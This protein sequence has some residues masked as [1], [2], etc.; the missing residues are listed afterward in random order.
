M[1]RYEQFL[2]YNI[3]N[4]EQRQR[5]R[6]IAIPTRSFI[7]DS[8]TLFNTY[9]LYQEVNQRNRTRW[10]HTTNGQA[11]GNHQPEIESTGYRR[12]NRQS[13]IDES[14]PSRRRRIEE[15]PV[16]K[17]PKFIR[18]S[19]TFKDRWNKEFPDKPCV[20]C[21]TLLLPRHRKFRDFDEDH[22]YG[23]TKV[24][25]MPVQVYES[26]V[27]VCESC[28][29]H[30]KHPIDCGTPPL[31]IQRLPHRSRKFISPFQLDTNLGRTTGYNLNAIPFLY[32]TLKGV[33]NTN[34]KNPRAIALYS[35][36]LGAWLESH[37]CN[38][39]DQGHDQDALRECRDWLLENNTVFQR[40][41]VRAYLQ[42][43]NPLPLAHLIDEDG[44]EQRPPNRPD[45]VMN[46][47]QYE[48]H[49]RDEHFRYNRLPVGAVQAS[50]D[51]APQPTLY[52]S[53]PDVE[54]LTFPH[55]YPYGRGQWVEGTRTEQGRL[56]Y[57]R[58]MDVKNKLN[59]VSSAFRDDWYWP[60][61]AYQ[62]MEATRIF[63]K[64]H[65]IHKQ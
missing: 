63:P 41:D 31:C 62:E 13:S 2:S 22:E 10:P 25:G 53:D 5:I 50:S 45:L 51:Q 33:I 6:A 59:S 48:Q 34:P 39:Y 37:R 55:L 12:R 42:V 29:S 15:V 47:F 44:D 38:Q 1:P 9:S 49:T 23:I 36:M 65:E 32:R 27:I 64:Y 11:T 54:V 56:Q 17:Q 24:F 35:G 19:K 8:N 58:H 20:E 26:K 21:A 61:W 18:K 16:E 3:V 43:G 30:P 7:P 40:N 52:R 60:S 57:T 46:P 28:Y 14:P 4:D